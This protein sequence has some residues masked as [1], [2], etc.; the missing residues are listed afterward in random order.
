MYRELFEA[1]IRI[2]ED[3]S[4]LGFD[5]IELGD[6]VQPKLTTLRQPVE[7]LALATIDLL[8]K[9]IEGNC[10]NQTLMFE[11]NLVEKESVKRLEIYENYHAMQNERREVY[12]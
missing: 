9:L 1:G 12:E 2:P 10:E 3:V 5:G 4:V 8:L 11:G 7:Q 6:Y